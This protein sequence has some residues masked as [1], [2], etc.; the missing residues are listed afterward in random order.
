MKCSEKVTRYEHKNI[1]VVVEEKLPSGTK[2]QVTVQFHKR[3]KPADE[4]HWKGTLDEIRELGEAVV[5]TLLTLS[6]E[7]E[8]DAHGYE[9]PGMETLNAGE[10]P[11]AEP[12]N[13]GAGDMVIQM[14][15][16]QFRDILDVSNDI[17]TNPSDKR[18][19]KLA[20]MVN[21]ALG[22]RTNY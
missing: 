1:I 22:G 3:S 2:G 10:G 14:T 15:I 18:S 7:P 11:R 19:S 8:R 12:P 13:P 5:S 16:E 17:L 20:L 9:V 6:P 4:S 21:K